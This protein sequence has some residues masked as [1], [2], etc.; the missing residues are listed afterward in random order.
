M[1]GL[2]CDF[3][4]DLILLHFVFIILSTYICLSIAVH[5]RDSKSLREMPNFPTVIFLRELNGYLELFLPFVLICKFSSGFGYVVDSFMLLWIKRI[6]FQFGVESGGRCWSGQ[7]MPYRPGPVFI[8]TWQSIRSP[9]H[10]A[11]PCP[12]NQN[13]YLNT[14]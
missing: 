11:V 2:F 1:I 4:M 7:S 8:A 14:L 12:T 3:K 13:S 6:C 5:L 9:S 10:I